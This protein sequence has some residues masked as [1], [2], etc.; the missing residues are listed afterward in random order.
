MFAYVF[1][2][3][4][5]GIILCVGSRRPWLTLLA[6]AL[7]AIDLF[8][9]MLTASRG[10]LAAFVLAAIVVALNTGKRAI[11]GLVLSVLIAVLIATVSVAP[12]LVT[13]IVEVVLQL[14]GEETEDIT[15]SG[16]AKFWEEALDKYF[17]HSPVLGSGANYVESDSSYIVEMASRG[18]VGLMIYI[19]L[20]VFVAR[21]GYITWRHSKEPIGR[22]LGL[23][24]FFATIGVLVQG[25]TIPVLAGSRPAELYWLLVATMWLYF[26]LQRRRSLQQRDYGNG[27]NGAGLQ[28]DVTV[29]P[30]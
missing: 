16:R 25:F 5:I 8:F 10:A 14:A 2:G 21:T 19:G 12:V 4:L 23:G 17:W 1:G 18:V 28:A 9:L 20:I 15:V 29:Q 26:P 11:A 24:V 30:A 22:A 27:K 13:R 6:Y 3:I 7:L